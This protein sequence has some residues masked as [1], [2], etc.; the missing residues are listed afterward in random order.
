MR[1]Y[2]IIEKKRDGY[3]L[4]HEELS[5]FIKGYC[6]GQIPD[7]QASALLMAMYLKGLNHRETAELTEIMADSGDRIDLSLIQGIKV[8]KHSTGGVGDKTTL[9][10]G[11][12]VAACGVPVAKMSG[13]G[14]GHTGG[15]IDKLESIPGFRTSLS[16]EEFIKN[17]ID[18]GISIAGQTGNLVPADK[19]LYALR[20]VTGTVS[21]ISLI[22]SSIMS[23]KIASGADRIVLDVK[24]GSGA[25][26]KTMGEAVELAKA[27]VEIGE[28]VGRRT[29]AVVTDMDIP[30][31]NAIGNSIEVIEAIETLKGQGPKD[32]EEVSFELAARMLELAD[33]GDIEACRIKVADAVKSGRALEKLEQLIK[34]QGG[35]SLVISQ[36]DRFEAAKVHYDVVADQGGYIEKIKTDS[37]GI[38]AMVLGAGRETKENTIDYSA[39]I[40]LKKKPG[41]KVEKGEVIARLYTSSEEKAR[42]AEN[43]I[44]NS[45]SISD[46][47][48]Q[49]SP[50][51]L[52]VIDKNGVQVMK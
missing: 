19:K 36:Y 42:E 22:A 49:L 26:M 15:T 5:F 35:D 25:F 37:L 32:L 48:V 27:M 50:L 34:R 16:K 12:I 4:S 45:I 29:V 39:G 38:G 30:L 2:D 44:K 3:E 28:Q 52:A 46:R 14:L 10:L 43:I 21:N 31:G 8:D 7:Y 24:C 23:K 1:M 13:R 41:M 40:L 33:G 6:N 47:Q 9:I 51:I 17:V 11:P 20:D 18:I